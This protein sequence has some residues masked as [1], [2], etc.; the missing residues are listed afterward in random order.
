MNSRLIKIGKTSKGVLLPN[1]SS[2]ASLENEVRIDLTDEGVLIKPIR[3]SRRKKWAAKIKKR[4]GQS[5]H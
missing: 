3:S 1:H 4:N 5:D 2:A